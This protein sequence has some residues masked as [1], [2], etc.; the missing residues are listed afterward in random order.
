VTARTVSA[1]TGNRL[2]TTVSG[3]SPRPPDGQYRPRAGSVGYAVAVPKQGES[4]SEF[5]PLTGDQDGDPVADGYPQDFTAEE[6]QSLYFGIGNQ[7]HRTVNYTVVVLLGE[8]RFQD[9]S[10]EVPRQE[11][12][13][14]FQTVLDSNETW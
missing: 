5:Y 11:R 3:R 2:R 7:E 1:S 4:F 6:G 14:R 10:S 8:V 12:S 9:N 13:G